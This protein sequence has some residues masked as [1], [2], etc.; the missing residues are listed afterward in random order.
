MASDFYTEDNM[1]R[2]QRHAGEFFPCRECGENGKVGEDLA[3]A[4]RVFAWSGGSS[5]VQ[6]WIH[7]TCAPQ[8]DSN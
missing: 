5:I 1:K 3:A 7:K 6:S 2:E 8:P 4:I